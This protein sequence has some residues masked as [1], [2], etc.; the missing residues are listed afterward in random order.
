M[1][2]AES[3]WQQHFRVGVAFRNHTT[4]ISGAQGYGTSWMPDRNIAR[5]QRPEKIPGHIRTNRSPK[6][7]HD[8]PTIVAGWRDLVSEIV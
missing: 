6:I 3:A 2:T 7:A 1:Q 4:C 5:Q 8:S